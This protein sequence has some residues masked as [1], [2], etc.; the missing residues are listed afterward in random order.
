MTSRPGF[1]LRKQSRKSKKMRVSVYCRIFWFL[2]L[3]SVT[4]PPVPSV[5]SSPVL[6]PISIEGDWTTITPHDLECPIHRRFQEPPKS[7]HQTKSYAVQT[8]ILDDK[9]L[10]EGTWCRLETWTTTCDYRWYGSQYMTYSHTAAIPS[11][12]ACLSADQTSSNRPYRGYHPRDCKY[13]QE[14]SV[15]NSVVTLRSESL[16]YD[17]YL[18]SAISSLFSSGHCSEQWCKSYAG[19]AL[20]KRSDFNSTNLCFRPNKQY[21]RLHTLPGNTYMKRAADKHQFLLFPSGRASPISELCKT[22]ICSKLGI[23]APWGEFIGISTELDKTLH[24]SRKCPEKFD[25]TSSR[26]IDLMDGLIYRLDLALMGERCFEERDRVLQGGEI[27]KLTLGKFSPMRPG[28]HPMYRLRNLT[29]EKNMG[30]YV[31]ARSS[32]SP[33]EFTVTLDH[34][35]T[36]TW[37]DWVPSGSDKV[38]SGFNGLW[39]VGHEVVHTEGLFYSQALSALDHKLET[40]QLLHHKFVGQSNSSV[41]DSNSETWTGLAELTIHP[42]PAAGGA[43]GLLGIALLVVFLIWLF[44]RMCPRRERIEQ[45][46][47]VAPLRRD[48]APNLPLPDDRIPIR[49]DQEQV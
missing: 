28:Y 15:V 8:L 11:I 24:V 42:A 23:S 41:T 30:F 20:W 38:L 13:N 6:Y 39:K 37:T 34:G 47:L 12:S 35:P 2:F 25:V 16:P 29:L 44:K 5:E 49:Y 26:E 32:G 36:M 21:V 46:E 1:S 27:G 18:D 22:T 33:S 9:A 19:K 45:R 48:E 4:L 40:I 3:L 31:L 17:P 7:N 10:V 14:T 43:M